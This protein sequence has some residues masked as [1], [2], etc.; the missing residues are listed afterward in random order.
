MTFTR[1]ALAL[2]VAVVLTGC[3]SLPSFTV[4]GVRDNVKYKEGGTS[5]NKLS[6]PPDLSAPD[7]DDTYVLNRVMTPSEAQAAQDQAIPSSIQASNAANTNALST[8]LGKLADGN[9][10]LIVN[11]DY[12]AV[13]ARTGEVLNR[14]G[15]QMTGQQKDKGL[16]AVTEPRSNTKARLIISDEGER[17]LIVVADDKGMPLNPQLAMQLLS[18][19]QAQI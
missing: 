19:L 18:L 12:N 14:A 9:P 10:A 2:G 5:V 7:F 13:W 1:N 17:S 11:G 16:Y 4:D 6:I 15:M 8:K 3:S